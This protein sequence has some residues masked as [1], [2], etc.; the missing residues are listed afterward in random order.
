M[1]STKKTTSAK[2]DKDAAKGKVGPKSDVQAMFADW[3]DKWRDVARAKPMGDVLA[4]LTVAAVALPLN[5]GLAM[6]CGLPPVA[7]LIAGA[8]GGFVAATFGG[9]P[10]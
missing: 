10:C 6:A 9:A 3:L 4:G 5:V 2:S 7:G 1:S 8:L